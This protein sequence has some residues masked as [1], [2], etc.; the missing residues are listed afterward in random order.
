MCIITQIERLKKALGFARLQNNMGTMS[1]QQPKVWRP[2]RPVSKGATAYHDAVIDAPY[3]KENVQELVE[4]AGKKIRQGDIVVDFGAGTGVSAA[5]LLKAMKVRFKLW[6]VDNSAAWL[7]KAYEIFRGN[8]DVECF[9]LEKINGRYATLAETLD[10]GI[11]DYVISAN[12]VHLVPDIG[13][14]FKGISEALKSKGSFVFQS[15]NI[16]RSG[17][18][19]GVL[20]I[21]NTVNSVHSMALEFIRTDSRFE[22][23]RAELDKRIK[24]EEKQRK[25]IFPEPRPLE[26]YIKSLTDAGFRIIETKYKLIRIK[27]YDWM[28]FL[29]VKRL[30]AGILPEGG[31]KEPSPEEENDRDMLITLAATKLFEDL[32][33]NNQMADETS[34]TAEWVYVT[35]EKD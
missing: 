25:F 13:Q 15:G 19:K 29:R 34:F 27:Y 16:L 14:A 24:I 4:I 8:P 10:R 35:A 26:A 5:Y 3:Y 12:T 20:M 21:D 17:R 32:K 2:D 7:G 18:K 11:V 1:L 23:Y 9:L 22:K 28:N 6:L 31:G 33:K 30:Q